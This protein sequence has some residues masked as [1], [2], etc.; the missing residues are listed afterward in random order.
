MMKNSNP[1]TVNDQEIKILITRFSP[2]DKVSWVEKRTTKFGLSLSAKNGVV[3]ADHGN[4]SVHVQYQNGRTA[5]VNREPLR[6]AEQTNAFAEALDE[7]KK[8]WDASA[9]EVNL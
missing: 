4:K 5:W 1:V 2:G 7:L 9:M 3:V 6:N 8:E